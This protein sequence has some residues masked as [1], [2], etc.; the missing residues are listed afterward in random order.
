MMEKM[1]SGKFKYNDFLKQ[2]KMI[3][4]MGSLGR[5]MKLVPG[6]G[7]AMKNVNTDDKQLVYIEAIIGSM[8][9]AERKNTKLISQSSS[10]RRRV[11]SG[12]GRSVSEVNKLIQSLEQ[13]GQM[14]KRMGSMD[15]S[16]INPN[17]PLAS[18]QGQPMKQ[19]KGKGKGKK[20]FRY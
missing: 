7:K 10:R 19:K 5:I 12:S 20:R 11:A 14:M 18:L 3:K 2:L 9:K 17:N 6:M 16:K 1:M 15:P 4:K 13:Q 8:T